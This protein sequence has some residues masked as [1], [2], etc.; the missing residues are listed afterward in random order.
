[1]HEIL[2]PYMQVACQVSEAPFLLIRLSRWGK[3]GADLG[4]TDTQPNCTDHGQ[5]EKQHDFPVKTSRR[6]IDCQGQADGNPLRF[7]EHCDTPRYYHL[8]GRSRLLQPVC[9][10][11]EKWHTP[12]VFGPTCIESIVITPETQSGSSASYLA[13]RSCYETMSGQRRPGA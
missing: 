6:P 5:D 12:E 11:L 9:L 8:S 13:T 2:L 1:M 3:G 10:R 4:L 7:W